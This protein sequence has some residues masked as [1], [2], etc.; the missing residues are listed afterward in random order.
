MYKNLKRMIELGMYP[1]MSE[2]QLRLDVFY[3]NGGRNSKITKAEY[4][5]LTQLLLD[6]ET[7]AY[8]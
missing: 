2:M 1:S 7:A 8:K 4:D 5:E 6:K 3:D